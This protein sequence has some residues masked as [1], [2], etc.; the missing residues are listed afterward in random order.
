MK[1]NN[2]KN[3]K[4]TYSEISQIS[5]ISIA[6][7]SRYYRDGYLSKEKKLILE[8]IISDYGL[9]TKDH[10]KL[11]K[12]VNY[13][14]IFALI[15]QWQ[16][17]KFSPIISGLVNE[18]NKV[19]QK[20]FNLYYNTDKNDFIENIYLA[21]KHNP[22]GIV[23]F[24]N[25]KNE[26]QLEFLKKLS[27]QCN[28][29]IYGYTYDGLNSIKID[30]TKAF[31]KLAYFM[32]LY[33]LSKKNIAKKLVYVFNNKTEKAIQNEKIA[34]IENYAKK[35]NIETAFYNLNLYSKKDVASFF[36]FCKKGSYKYIVSSTREIFVS[37]MAG[38]SDN[39][40][41]TDIGYISIYDQIR[42]Y[43]L[44]I[45]IDYPNIGIEFHRMI[46]SYLLESE[47]GTINKNMEVEIIK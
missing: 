44:K 47:S 39:L 7:I 13:N 12:T 28:I 16:N 32:D 22:I 5:G 25:K 38:N 10:F 33:F 1:E 4:L 23:V 29:F 2:S 14:L 45:H 20:V 30:F 31:Y 37:L 15:P 42:N 36:E 17:H 40:Y 41:I 9:E 26:E 43:L 27:D 24:F 21:L 46:S 11:T 3:K 8:K 19:K 35:N 34:G 6:S 18:A